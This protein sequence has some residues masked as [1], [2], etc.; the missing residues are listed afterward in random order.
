MKEPIA[1]ATNL[2]YGVAGVFMI[3]EG[4]ALGIYAGIGS[5][6]LMLGSAWFH[7]LRTRLGQTADE[8][9][10]Y[11]A[12]VALD[13]YLFAHLFSLASDAAYLIAIG[14]LLTLVLATN[15]DKIDS[16]IAVPA[17]ALF[18]V[19]LVGLQA[20]WIA[21]AGLFIQFAIAVALRQQGVVTRGMGGDLL[22]GIWHILTGAA[23]LFAFLLAA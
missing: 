1:T 10:M 7:G 4:S 5:I 16:F 2:A 6:M 18:G 14:V 17:L 8:I 21:A 19:L 22:H 3:A 23:L 11:A 13:V 9:A 12:I 15:W 20:T